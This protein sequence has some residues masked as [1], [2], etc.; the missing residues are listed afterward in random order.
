MKPYP[1]AGLLNFDLSSAENEDNRRIF[2]DL[3]AEVTTECKGK[4]KNV[5]FLL[6]YCYY[7]NK[8]YYIGVCSAGCQGNGFT[9]VRVP[10]F[11]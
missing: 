3:V 11:K 7:I 8:N 4:N 6:K 10:L 9:S 1:S 5:Q 2:Q